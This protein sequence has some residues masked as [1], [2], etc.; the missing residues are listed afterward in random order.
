MFS[1]HFKRSGEGIV[2]CCRCHVVFYFGHTPVFY[3]TRLHSLSSPPF[4]SLLDGP[5]NYWPGTYRVGVLYWVLDEF[6][7][8]EESLSLLLREV[9][10]YVSV[11]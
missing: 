6:F 5:N 11:V 2:L 4:F 3:A 8:R 9:M 1:F 7:L 10:V